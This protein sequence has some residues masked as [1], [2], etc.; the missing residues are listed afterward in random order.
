MNAEINNHKHFTKMSDQSRAF[1][2]KHVCAKE[3]KS[4]NEAPG[5]WASVKSSERI[6]GGGDSEREKADQHTKTY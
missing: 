2:K 3:K 1:E 4:G 6:R 5:R